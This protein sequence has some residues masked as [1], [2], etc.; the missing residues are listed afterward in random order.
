MFFFSLVHGDNGKSKVRKFVNWFC[1]YEAGT[2]EAV[3]A[4]QANKLHLQ[5]LTSLKQDPYAETFLKGNLV[6][7]LAVGLYL[8]IYFSL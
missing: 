7:I 2:Q 6:L 5:N 8:Y 3:R 4:A 1:G